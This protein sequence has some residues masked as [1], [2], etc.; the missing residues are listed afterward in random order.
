MTITQDRRPRG[1][2]SNAEYVPAEPELTAAAAAPAQG[3]L[4]HSAPGG[5][6]AWQG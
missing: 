3:T 5:L 1:Q 4:R 6:R 2:G